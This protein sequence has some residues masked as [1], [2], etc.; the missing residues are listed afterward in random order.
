MLDNTEETLETMTPPPLED[1]SGLDA[2]A[3]RQ[4]ATSTGEITPASR[5]RCASG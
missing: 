5:S 4:R 3:L 1:L 2:E